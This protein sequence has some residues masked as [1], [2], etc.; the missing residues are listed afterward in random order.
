MTWQANL[1]DSGGADWQRAASVLRQTREDLD[2]MFELV[3]EPQSKDR[4]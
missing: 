2:P 4:P 3:D 1:V